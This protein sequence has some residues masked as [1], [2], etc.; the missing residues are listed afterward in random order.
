MKYFDYESVTREARIPEKKLRK[1]V[2]LVRREF[3][4]DLM[5]AELHT[6]RACLA[7]RNG[8][9]Q[10]DNALKT[11]LRARSSQA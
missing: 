4:H 10:I 9:I 8:H 6:L 1:L 3:P 5:M 7:V 11:K 2:K